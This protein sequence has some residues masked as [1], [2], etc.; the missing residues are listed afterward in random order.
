MLSDE[1]ATARLCLRMA[2]DSGSE[3]QLRQIVEGVCNR[4]ELIEDEAV[5]WQGAAVIEPLAR[6][7][8][9]ETPGNIVRFPRG[10]Q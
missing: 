5:T 7:P 3:K 10:S 9:G 2:L 1:I 4:L 8:D 6:L